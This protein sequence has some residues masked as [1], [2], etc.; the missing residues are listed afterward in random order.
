MQAVDTFHF[1]SFHSSLI[2]PMT[3]TYFYLYYS[4]VR[5][6]WWIFSK[7]TSYLWVKTLLFII[8]FFY[9]APLLKSNYCIIIVISAPSPSIFLRLFLIILMHVKEKG[10]A[11]YFIVIHLEIGILMLKT[12]SYNGL[13]FIEC[14]FIFL[15]ISYLVLPFSDK[16]IQP[17]WRRWFSQNVLYVE[18]TISRSGFW[19]I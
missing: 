4:V 17:E 9:T 7:M 10:H 19:R 15:V 6:I 16:V 13:D 8:S 12:P 2:L 14:I 18:T 1:P 3:L 11:Y 5:A